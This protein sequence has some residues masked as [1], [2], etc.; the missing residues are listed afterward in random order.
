MN[1]LQHATAGVLD[2]YD[3]PISN[4][5]RT[6]RMEK[7][8]IKNFHAILFVFFTLFSW[9]VFSISW[10]FLGLMKEKELDNMTVTVV[11]FD[12]GEMPV[13][14]MKAGTRYVEIDEVFGNQ[15]IKDKKNEFD[16]DSDIIDPRVG[17]AVNPMVSNATIPIDLSPEVQP[18]YTSQARSAGI[19]GTVILELIISDEG[20][21][22]RAKPVGKQLGHGLEQS[23]SRCFRRKKFKPSVN[24]SGKSITVKIYQPVRFALI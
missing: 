24:S 5:F 7:W 1:E 8:Y 13:Y 22:L 16:P 9:A 2:I 4:T 15:F 6:E 10:D 11:D 14:N 19:Q 17:T 23:A 21:V 18:E 3:L 12:F 20:D